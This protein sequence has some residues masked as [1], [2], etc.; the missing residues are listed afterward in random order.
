MYDN[1]QSSNVI[2]RNLFSR[3]SFITLII[4][5]AVF[6]LFV[7][8]NTLVLSFSNSQNDLLLSLYY[9]F[10]NNSYFTVNLIFGILITIPF[11]TVLYGMITSYFGAS[12]QD[13]RKLELGTNIILGSLIYMVIFAS[14]FVIISFASVSVSYYTSTLL[15]NK[16]TYHYINSSE[17]FFYYVL[18]GAGIITLLVA[19]IR[20]ILSIRRIL[21]K[22][23]VTTK[24]AGLSLVASIY[25]ASITAIS[26]IVSLFN[27]LM[28]YE[29][30]SNDVVFSKS[31]LLILMVA[32]LLSASMTIILIDMSI[33]ISIYSSYANKFNR[34]N[35]QD[36][37]SYYATNM[38]NQYP[39]RTPYQ[40]PVPPRSPS[41]MTKPYN[42]QTHEEYLKATNQ[43]QIQNK[44]QTAPSQDIDENKN[45]EN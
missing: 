18:F 45:T 40:N 34:K 8:I 17:K 27:L 43:N 19:L 39:N 24:G 42:Q 37:Y 7:L 11:A 6:T 5:T 30:I 10:G 32:I 16:P 41:P 44:E 22:Q 20:L 9:F 26:F 12:K 35:H 15:D 1:T 23:Q 29:R 33:L 28:P 2:V 25:C 14:C 21:K 38:Y 31:S 36:Y 13:D 4:S 3:T